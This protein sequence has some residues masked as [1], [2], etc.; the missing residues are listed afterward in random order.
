[1]LACLQVQ[2]C[3]DQTVTFFVSM[4][5]PLG[6]E[7]RYDKEATRHELT[8]FHGLPRDSTTQDSCGEIRGRWRAWEL[9]V[10]LSGMLN[11]AR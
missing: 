4:V 10:K 1:M 8:A 2:V 5:P 11:L 3:Q 7:P 6:R 9:H